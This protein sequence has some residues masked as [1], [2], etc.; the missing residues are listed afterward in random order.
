M[1]RWRGEME[2]RKEG[3]GWA[4]K[5]RKCTSLTSRRTWIQGLFL[6]SIQQIFTLASAVLQTEGQRCLAKRGMQ[7]KLKRLGVPR[8][9]IFSK[10]QIRALLENPGHRRAEN[11]QKNL[12]CRMVRYSL[13]TVCAGRMQPVTWINPGAPHYPV[14]ART[15][16]RCKIQQPTVTEWGFQSCPTSAQRKILDT[17][18]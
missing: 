15:R 9:I 1:R 2:R 14:S 3:K 12:E 4:H 6:S 16:Q 11:P 17:K 10:P 7:S 5:E 8:V 18:W 13:C